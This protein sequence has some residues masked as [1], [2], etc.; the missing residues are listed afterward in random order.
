[1]TWAQRLLSPDS[2]DI[3]QQGGALDSLDQRLGIRPE[4]GGNDEAVDE[5]GDPRVRVHGEAKV[6]VQSRGAPLVLEA[7]AG[8]TAGEV[9]L[10]GQAVGLEVTVA[11]PSA[12]TPSSSLSMIRGE[13]RCSAG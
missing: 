11:E 12:V 2:A 4:G 10:G 13:V 3:P 1:V 5:R 9:A 7:P 8:V 6:D